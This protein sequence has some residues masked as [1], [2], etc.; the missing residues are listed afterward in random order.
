M[1]TRASSIACVVPHNGHVLWTRPLAALT[2]ASLVSSM[3]SLMSAVALPWFVLQTTGSPSRVGLVLAAEA[4]SLL[5]FAVPNERGRKP[6]PFRR[7]SG[8]MLVA[9]NRRRRSS[10]P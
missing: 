5:L 4:V 10:K 1:R 7:S 8:V 9:S 3:G 6:R 2:A